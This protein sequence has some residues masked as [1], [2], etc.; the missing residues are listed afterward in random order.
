MLH[1]THMLDHFRKFAPLVI[2]CMAVSSAN[3]RGLR[4]A[5]FSLAVPANLTYPEYEREGDDQSIQF[6][7]DNAAKTS[8]FCAS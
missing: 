6:S 7:D 2:A 1:F 8:R 3:R 5:S 4:R